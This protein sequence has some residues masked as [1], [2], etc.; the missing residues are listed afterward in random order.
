MYANFAKRS[1]QTICQLLSKAKR[2]A[3]KL[4]MSSLSAILA[5]VTSA[6]AFAAHPLPVDTALAALLAENGL[7]VPR[8]TSDSASPNATDEQLIVRRG[9]CTDD[10]L[11][12]RIS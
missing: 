4:T 3:T 12:D 7:D 10:A 11:A 6:D 8:R 2:D 1:P 5:A 9:F